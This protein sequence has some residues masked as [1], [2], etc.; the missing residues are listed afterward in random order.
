MKALMNLFAALIL[1]FCS[2]AMAASAPD[3]DPVDLVEST[4]DRV[5][6]E[7]RED[8]ERT[9]EDPEF[10][11]DLVDEIILP[12]IDFQGMSRLIL[13]RHWRT[14][15]PEQ[16]EA[17]TD[18]FRDM[19]V[20]TYTQ[21]MAEHMDKEIRVLSNRSFQD[22]RMAAVA[23]EIVMGEGESNIPVTYRLR[24]VDG[25]WKVFDLEVEGLSFITNFRTTFGAEVEKEGLDALIRRLEQGDE[26]IVEEAV[27]AG[28]S[29]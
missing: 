27:E 24:P 5:L 9:R 29:S 15:T 22:D 13:A 28:E 20:R 1:G 4:A 26:S 23:T 10:L 25:Q 6:S 8:P 11:Y 7:L 19:L 14:A 2:T 17:F 16:R 3:Q 12:M 21:Q 18:A